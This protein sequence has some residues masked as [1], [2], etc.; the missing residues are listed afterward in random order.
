MKWRLNFRQRIIAGFL[1]LCCAFILIIYPFI[2]WAFRNIANSALKRQSEILIGKLQKSSSQDEMIHRLEQ[3]HEYVFYRAS[4]YNDQGKMLYDALIEAEK[5]DFSNYGLSHNQVL[6]V[7]DKGVV[8]TSGQSKI[9]HENLL[10]VLIAFQHEGQNYILR[11]A[12]PYDPL[13]ALS[14]QIRTEFLIFC[15]LSL[16]FFAG[17][18]WL[19]F[20]RINYPIKQII[21]AIRPFQSGQEEFISSIVLPKSIDEDDQF[22]RLAETLNALSERIRTQ[23]RHIMEERNEKEAILESLG[24]GVLAIDRDMRIRYVNFIGSRMIGFPRKQLAGK[25]FTELALQAQNHPF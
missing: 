8:Y 4:L 13:K 7:L 23:I 5:K 14:V 22:Y 19:I 11:T 1:L 25:S 6:T 20:H 12:I 24:E 10:Y 21:K 2:G 9:Y 16:L 3:I 17:C 15:F 18:F